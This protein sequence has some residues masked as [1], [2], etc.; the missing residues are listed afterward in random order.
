[1]TVSKCVTETWCGRETTFMNQV[2]RKTGEAQIRIVWQDVRL[3]WN[4][5]FIWN[6]EISEARKNYVDIKWHYTQKIISNWIRNSYLK[7][8]AISFPGTLFWYFMKHGKVKIENPSRSLHA[9]MLFS[10]QVLC[11]FSWSGIL[12]WNYLS[13]WKYISRKIYYSNIISEFCEYH[14][15]ICKSLY[16]DEQRISVYTKNERFWSQNISFLIKR[17]MYGRSLV[18]KISQGHII[19]RTD[20]FLFFFLL[21]FMR[22]TPDNPAS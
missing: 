5:G 7:N 16:I 11:Y 18:A 12:E 8:N 6:V 15:D 10:S 17:L 20:C 13:D 9:S 14:C 4:K 22:T 3:H 19:A 21:Y 2:R 1:M